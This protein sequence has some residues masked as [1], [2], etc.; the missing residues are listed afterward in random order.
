[1]VLQCS[2]LRLRSLSRNFLWKKQLRN[3]RRAVFNQNRRSSFMSVWRK[4]LSYQVYIYSTSRLV[5]FKT[6]NSGRLN[7]PT[8]SCVK[9]PANWISNT[10]APPVTPFLLKTVAR[11]YIFKSLACSFI[12]TL[13]LS[14]WPRWNASWDTQLSKVCKSLVRC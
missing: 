8:L 13:P 12:Y 3:K 4:Q 9:I 7:V 11:M 2:S 1:M 14:S 6:W 10:L 5:I